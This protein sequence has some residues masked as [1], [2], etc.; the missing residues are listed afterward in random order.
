MIKA[1]QHAIQTGTKLKM[2]C[3]ESDRVYFHGFVFL[4]L[5]RWMPRRYIWI[6]CPRYQD[7]EERF[8]SQILANPRQG[9]RKPRT[10]DR[11]GWLCT[12]SV[13]CFP[14]AN[15]SWLTLRDIRSLSFFID[16]I[17]NFTF[18]LAF[19]F[20]DFTTVLPLPLN[21][22]N[23]EWYHNTIVDLSFIFLLIVHFHSFNNVKV[24]PH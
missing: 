12:A 10:Q 23:N 14:D 9:N 15:Y 2:M 7:L 17:L 20:N 24:R 3:K 18:P 11:K 16:V 13:F 19:Y 8:S 4:I 21:I 5:K 1:P 22:K 6:I